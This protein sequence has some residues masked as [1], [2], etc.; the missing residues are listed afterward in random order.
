MESILFLTIDNQSIPLEQALRYLDNAGKL[1]MMLGEIVRQHVIEQELQL[2][3]LNLNTNAI[4]QAIIDF[5]LENGLINAEIFEQWLAEESLTYS[6]FRQQISYQIQLGE[7]KSQIASQNIQEYFIDRKLSLDRVVLSRL[8]VKE[9]SVA[10]ELRTQIIEEG[11][12]F[13][14]LVQEYSIA[15]DRIVN[16]M[17][18]AISRGGLPDSLRPALDLAKPGDVLEPLEIDDLWYLVRFERYLPATLDEQLQQELEEELF[19][20]WLDAKIAAIEVEFPVEF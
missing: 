15:E 4:E 11:A 13:E 5:R 16:G 18:G 14:E 9:Q 10:E 7:L 20:Q 6:N 17:M 1:E 3:Q 19:E 12:K 8:V 2:Q